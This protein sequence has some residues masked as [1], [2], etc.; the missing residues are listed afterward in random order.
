MRSGIRSPESKRA[1][2]EL[3][4]LPG[5]FSIVRLGPRARIPAAALTGFHSI[6]RTE[7]ELSIICRQ[8]RA[9]RLGRR[10]DGFRCLEVAGPLPFEATG[11]L[12]AL[13]APLARAR[14]PILAVGTF[15]TDYLFVREERLEAAV[16][17]LG[18]AGHRVRV[19]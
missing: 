16:R 15:D 6:T 4:V 11:V 19:E 9:P 8:E 17:A 7:K 10:E 3:A 14:I 5:L 18:R 1:R 12:A 2:F 13:A